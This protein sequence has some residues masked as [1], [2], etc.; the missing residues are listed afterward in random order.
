M[1]VAGIM[2][3]NNSNRL[4]DRYSGFVDNIKGGIN[5]VSIISPQQIAQHIKMQESIPKGE[6]LLTRLETPFLLNFKRNKI[7]IADWPGGASPPPGMPLFKG[8]E[9]LADYLTS[10]LLEINLIKSVNFYSLSRNH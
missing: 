2:I 9:P 7:F 10:Q 8:S 6:T 4:K 3:G 1:V 5:G